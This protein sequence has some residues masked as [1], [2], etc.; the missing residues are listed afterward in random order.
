VSARVFITLLLCLV[1]QGGELARANSPGQETQNDGVIHDEFFSGSVTE[2]S[3][4]TVAVC[5]TL[6][7]KDPETKVFV[8][9]SETIIEGKLKKAVRV[10]VGYRT[11]DGQ[12]HAWRIIV[13]DSAD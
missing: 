7:G 4:T 11:H 3:E 2:V 12:D 5:R 13:R 1:F 10:T 9:D 6:P 8:V